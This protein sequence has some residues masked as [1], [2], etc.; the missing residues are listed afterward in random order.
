MKAFHEE[1]QV[2]R[3]EAVRKKRKPLKS[4]GDTNLIKGATHNDCIFKQAC[5]MDR[6]KRQ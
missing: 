4:S 3:H 5:A 1:M 6:A 2:I